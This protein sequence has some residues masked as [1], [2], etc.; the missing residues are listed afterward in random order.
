[1]ADRTN[2]LKRFNVKTSAS[3]F[4]ILQLP[5]YIFWFLGLKDFVYFPE[6]YNIQGLQPFLWMDS[7]Y[8]PDPYFIIPTISSFIT[9]L[10]MKKSFSKQW[11]EELSII[12]FRKLWPYLPYL[13]FAGI[14]ILATMPA[15]I[16]LYF[17]VLSLSNLV[18]MQLM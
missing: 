11:M 6:K 3:I 4:N 7:I 18:S 8:I 15:S 9:Y 12:I 14:P 5:I 10:T 13:P 2:I 16:N 1:M 17:L